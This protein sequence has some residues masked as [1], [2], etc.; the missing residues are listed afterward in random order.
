VGIVLY[1]GAMLAGGM[2]QGHHLRDGA[3]PFIDVM[4]GLKMFLRISTLGLLFL[5]VGNVV[6]FGSVAGMI[7][8]CC[9][10]CCCPSEPVSKVKLKPAKAR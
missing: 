1:S 4:N 7:R 8:Q 9:R 6:I 5:L 10:N 3:V 2:S